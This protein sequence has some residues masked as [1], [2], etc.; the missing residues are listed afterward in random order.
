MKKW[1]GK[2]RIGRNARVRRAMQSMGLGA[3]PPGLYQFQV[4]AVKL[5]EATD[6][7]AIRFRMVGEQLGKTLQGV[8]KLGP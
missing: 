3:L 7:L 4:D 8:V 1:N 6:Q 5:M 2:K